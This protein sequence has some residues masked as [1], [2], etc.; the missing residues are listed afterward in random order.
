[1]YYSPNKN[2]KS[3]REL[4]VDGPVPY[5]VPTLLP[6]SNT[7]NIHIHSLLQINTVLNHFHA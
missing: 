6:L 7:T 5:A 4:M 1:M 2:K 3:L